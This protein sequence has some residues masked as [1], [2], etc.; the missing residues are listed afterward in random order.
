MRIE[1]MIIP[2]PAEII[3]QNGVVCHLGKINWI[4]G[5]GV[6]KS[7]VKCINDALIAIGANPLPSH[8]SKM[9]L[10]TRQRISFNVNAENLAP[11]EYVLNIS[12]ESIVIEGG[13]AAGVFYG[14]QS[15]VQML[16]VCSELGGHDRYLPVCVIK[17]R[18]R[19]K[20]RGIMIDSARHFQKPEILLKLV[21]EMAKYK[22]NVLHWHLVDRQSWRLP[23]ACAPELLKNVPRSRAYVFGA[24]TK[25]DIQRVVEYAENRYI[26][27]IPEIEMPGHSAAVFYTH[28]ELACPVSP[29][30]YEDD[31]WE[32]CIGNDEVEIFL[33]KILQECV[34]LFPNSKYIHIG[35]DEASDAH[36]RNCPRC[37]KKMS[38]L[39]FKEPR[40][41][42][43]YFM[44]RME[45]V[46]N[47]LGR[48][49]IS[50][51]I[52]HGDGENFTGRMVIQNWLRNDIN[53]YLNGS[54]QVINS[55]HV[56]NYFDYPA[57]DSEPV[58]DYQ[59]RN[60]EFD[61]A[62]GVTPEKISLVL[63]GEGCIWSEQ[64]PQ[65]RVLP[66]AIPRMRALAEI[67]WSHPEHKDFD[68]FLLRERLLTGSGLYRYC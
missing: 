47:N 37:Q 22:L 50:W 13:D 5:A 58:V 18:P 57:G 64:I 1:N 21:D 41:L 31:F 49:A 39:G 45:Q 43:Q 67:L 26:Q 65:W 54:H 38:S 53:S 34:E 63:G 3:E 16:A 30:P 28:P 42:E 4:E 23:L 48:Q 59:H 32:F 6:C 55:F 60:Y 46:V 66:R 9:N 11:E 19:F 20:Y 8:L 44:A 7:G 2:R 17:D 52:P 62:A 36:W 51:G 10:G 14:A 35:G 12:N 40:E 61:P 68:N 15:L 33:T 27:V 29:T 24:Y 56:N 25:E